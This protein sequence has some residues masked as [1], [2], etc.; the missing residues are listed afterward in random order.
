LSDLSIYRTSP[1]TIERRRCSPHLAPKKF[2][3]ATKHC[4]TVGSVDG[5]CKKKT[6]LGDGLDGAESD[7][8]V[9]RCPSP[10]RSSPVS[11]AARAGFARRATSP[12][13]AAPAARRA[14]RPVARRGPE[15][16]WRPAGAVKRR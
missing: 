13:V 9:R 4:L 16:V 5:H 8:R 12:P 3:V 14:R 15:S 7:R 1:A 11:G 6:L 10:S 2:F